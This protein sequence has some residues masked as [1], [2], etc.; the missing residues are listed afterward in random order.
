M[1]TKQMTEAEVKALRKQLVAF[2][3]PKLKRG[4]CPCCIG[5]AMVFAALDVGGMGDA[6]HIIAAVMQGILDNNPDIKQEPQV[7]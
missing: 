6:T 4:C 5:S 2:I 1:T 7:Q 3:K